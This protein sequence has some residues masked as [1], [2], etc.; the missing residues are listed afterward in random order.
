MFDAALIY[1]ARAERESRILDQ[2]GLTRNEYILATVHRAENADDPDRLRTIVV[3][4]G[5]IA[6]S[7]T[8]VWPL[9]PRTQATLAQMGRLQGLSA[10]KLIDPV[11]YLD[12][13][14][15]E[16]HSRLIVTDSGGVQ[17]EA[18]F[19]RTPCVTLREETEWTELV[20]LG[21]NHLAPPTDG[22]LIGDTIRK[23][24][25]SPPGKKATPFGSGNAAAAIVNALAGNGPDRAGRTTGKR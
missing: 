2:H 10:L 22:H 9:H 18:F 20:E 13:L 19:F 6:T 3:A 24:L 14:M 21:W 5:E 25:L 17:K 7:T 12:M 23:A 11:G 1:G 8:V 4:L 16:R 15:L